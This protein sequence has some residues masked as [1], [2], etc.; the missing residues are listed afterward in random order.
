MSKRRSRRSQPNLPEET[1]AR[2]RREA[3]LEESLPEEESPAAAS[4][5]HQEALPA[6]QRR[7]RQRDVDPEAMTQIEIA[8]LLANPTKVVSEDTL[9]EQYTYV[10][11]DLRSMGALAALLFVIMIVAARFL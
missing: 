11:A 5:R 1:L 10:T 7:K 4:P 3:G 6:V 2:A 9:R 8:D